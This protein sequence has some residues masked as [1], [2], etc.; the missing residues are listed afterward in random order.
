MLKR[1][2]LLSFALAFLSLGAVAQPLLAVED[3]QINGD[4]SNP[5]LVVDDDNSTWEFEFTVTTNTNKPLGNQ[6]I[7]RVLTID[8]YKV[9]G[10]TSSLAATIIR[11][12]N[13]VSVGTKTF[14]FSS[15]DINLGT[16][17]YE[18][19]LHARY[20]TTVAIGSGNMFMTVKKNGN[21]VC[22]Q[23]SFAID[24]EVE[25]DLGLI[26]CFDYQSCHAISL[27]TSTDK[28]GNMRVNLNVAG[29]NTFYIIS[30]KVEEY[31]VNPI[32]GGPG[33][34]YFN[35]VYSAPLPCGTW[36][37]SVTVEDP[38]TGCVMK[39]FQIFTH[40]CATQL[41]N[42]KELIG[43][44]FAN[45][46]APTF[47][48]YPNPVAN[49]LVRLSYELPT[50]TTQAQL[51]IHNLQGQLV[52]RLNIDPTSTDIKIKLGDLAN[53][54]YVASLAADGQRIGMQRMLLKQ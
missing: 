42:D 27:S 46:E 38:V 22:G 2:Y 16:G 37:Y 21:T 12:S 50:N 18:V 45:S 6:A 29:K 34:M 23:Q 40:P 19:Y 49:G 53:G 7:F 33:T 8:I 39:L 51:E 9:D 15:E 1:L 30:W 26:T 44:R 35:D 54:L 47:S 20:Y 36:T 43:G 31:K 10:G 14:G 25:C 41:P 52:K 17:S 48:L 28:F 32:P 13:R 24:K 4:C 5:P 11:G 3:F